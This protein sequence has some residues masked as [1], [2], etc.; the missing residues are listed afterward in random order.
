MICDCQLNLFNCEEKV[1]RFLGAGRPDGSMDLAAR[2]ELIEK[3]TPL[4][5]RIVA[6]KLQGRWRQDRACAVQDT[7]LKLCDP[8]KLRTW[9]ENPKRTWFCH[10]VAVVA[11]HAAIDWVRRPDSASVGGVDILPGAASTHASVEL[12]ELAE[13]LRTEIIAGLF[14]FKWEWQLVFCM[15]FSYLEPSVSDI[16]HAVNVSEEAV[17]FRLRK[18]KE[19]IA[20]RCES[21]LSP[22]VAKAAL[23]GTCHPVDGFNRLE[24]ARRDQVNAAIR[25]LLAARPLKEQYAFSMKYS[26]LAVSPDLLAAQLQEDENTVRGWLATIEK[27]IQHLFPPE[28]Y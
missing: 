20:C 6:S 1:R 23:V 14:E 10:W 5:E 7:F 4:V 8:A 25:G 21:L 9:L 2:D 18:I 12:Q 24:P 28:Q 16:A 17:F 27:E 13:R 22:A 11:S 3:M 26:P 19:R 15:K